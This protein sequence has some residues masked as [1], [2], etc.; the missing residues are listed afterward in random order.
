MIV[1]KELVLFDLLSFHF[2]KQVVPHFDDAVSVVDMA[3][4]EV[5]QV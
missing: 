2:V 1:I 3:L 5:V 4:D